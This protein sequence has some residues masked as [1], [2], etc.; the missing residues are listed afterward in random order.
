MGGVVPC[1]IEAALESIQGRFV[2]W[3]ATPSPHTLLL[4][5][6]TF[7]LAHRAFSLTLVE[8]I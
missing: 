7:K 5:D 2:H 6:A 8:L 3:I 4:L 1:F